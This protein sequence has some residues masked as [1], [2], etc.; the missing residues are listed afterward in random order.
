MVRKMLVVTVI[1][2]FQA[3]GVVVQ[4]L[5]A[6]LI[7]VAA[8]KLHAMTFPY[9]NPRIDILESLGIITFLIEQAE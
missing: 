6:L 4:G 7:F 5:L 2:L 3:Q 9:S 1:F 8:Q